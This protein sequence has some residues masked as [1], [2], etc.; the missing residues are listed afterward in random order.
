MVKVIATV[1]EWTMQQAGLLLSLKGDDLFLHLIKTLKDAAFVSDL[2]TLF[3]H[4]RSVSLEINKSL[5]HRGYCQAALNS[6]DIGVNKKTVF[7]SL[8]IL[9]SG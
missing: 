2:I 8:L 9:R 7:K 5:V 3:N 1:K 4:V 6:L